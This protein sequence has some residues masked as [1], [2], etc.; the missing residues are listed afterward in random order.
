M[1]YICTHSEDPLYTLE[2]PYKIIHNENNTI[3]SEQWRHLRGMQLILNTSLPKEIG[4]FQKR[5][6]LQETAIPDG[7]D[8]VV[9]KNFH[10]VENIREQ[11]KKYHSIE[12]LDLVEKI[13]S[14]KSFSK[15]IRINNNL[16]CYFDNV[17]I[18][19]RNDYITYCIK[20]FN[21]LNIKT[22]IAGDKDNC[23]LAERIG[24]YLIYKMFNKSKIY[25]SDVIIYE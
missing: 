13:I 25:E 23:F 16:Q 10:N 19:R 6:R 4:I 5:R 8:V 11:Y 18:M 12:N 2:C 22:K 24:S 15:Y 17:F 7:Y 3:L 20:L 21:I 9:P 1:I 14:E